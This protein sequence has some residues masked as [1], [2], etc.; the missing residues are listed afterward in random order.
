MIAAAPR[1]AVIGSMQSGALGWFAD[2][3]RV[4]NLDGVVDA[5]ARRAVATGRLCAFVRERGVTHL[6]DWAMNRELFLSRCGEPPPTLRLV[7][8]AP[9]QGAPELRF[10]LYAVD[11]AGHP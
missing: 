11:F 1:G 10:R 8:E 9:P 4:V 3:V 2:G 7:A 6:A 5:D